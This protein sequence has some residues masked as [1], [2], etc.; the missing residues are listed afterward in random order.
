LFFLTFGI[1]IKFFGGTVEDVIESL[2]ICPLCSAEHPSPVITCR[3][4]QCQ[5]LLINKIKLIAYSLRQAGYSDLSLRFY[6]K[7]FEIV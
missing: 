7:N 1:L 3:R 6:D 2:W 4:C 5:L